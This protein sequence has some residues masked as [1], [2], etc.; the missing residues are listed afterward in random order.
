MYVLR[1]VSYL[2]YR[3]GPI[4]INWLRR[5]GPYVNPGPQL[6][7]V[8]GKA[9]GICVPSSP[10]QSPTLI[11]IIRKLHKQTHTLLDCTICRLAHDPIVV[12]AENVYYTPLQ[13]DIMEE[14]EKSS[15]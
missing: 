6:K 12:V 3:F 9:R 14:E 2:L 10:R 8:K 1:F 7:Y 5:P 13:Q 11:W 15:L 4:L